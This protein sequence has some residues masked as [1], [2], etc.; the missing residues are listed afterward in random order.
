MGSISRALQPILH[1]PAHRAQKSPVPDM[2][3]SAGQA[4]PCAVA[5]DCGGYDDFQHLIRCGALNKV[6]ADEGFFGAPHTN[7][8]TAWIATGTEGCA[9]GRHELK[10]HYIR[11]KHSCKKAIPPGLVRIRTYVRFC[12]PFLILCCTFSSTEFQNSA[13]ASFRSSCS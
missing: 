1:E 4:G 10:G 2:S 13:S 11:G 12:L 5:D 8:W 3:A 7:W 9:L 6:I